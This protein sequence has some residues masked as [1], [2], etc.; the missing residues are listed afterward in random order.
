MDD[1]ERFQTLQKAADANR[2]RKGDK[3]AVTIRA[4]DFCFLVD[5]AAAAEAQ[6][7][8]QNAGK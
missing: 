6:T 3:D 7:A 4:S 1:R 2:N 5:R 8:K